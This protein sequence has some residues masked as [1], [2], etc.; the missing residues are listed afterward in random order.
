MTCRPNS[1]LRCLA[2]ALSCL[3]FVVNPA[4][5]Q[6]QD[7]T[8]EFDLAGT[9][10]EFTLGASFHTVHGTF[11]LKSGTIHFNPATGAASGIV[12]ADAASADTGNKSRDRKMHAEVLESRQYPEV[13]FSP[14]RISGSVALPGDS[15]IQVEGIFRLHGND[16]P[17][18]L[19]VPVQISGG[20]VTARTRFTV[21]YV[22]WGLRNPSNLFLH[23]S[24]KV[25]VEVSTTG[26]ITK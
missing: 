21:P 17:I 9:K 25:E 1:P 6:A 3:V 18:E 12:I 2:L 16:H 15:T 4:R 8:V 20:A 14:T 26:R 7:T 22:A 11:Q 5:L 19:T 13:T 23:V 10:I 24:D